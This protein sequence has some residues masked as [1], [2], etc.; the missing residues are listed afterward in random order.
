MLG[1]KPPFF[2]PKIFKRRGLCC[3]KSPVSFE[4]LRILFHNYHILY[5]LY[6]LSI[7]SQ[8]GSPLLLRFLLPDL[9][10]LSILTSKI[11]GQ[12]QIRSPLPQRKM[13]APH[14]CASPSDKIRQFS[15]IFE[16]IR[17]NPPPG[18]SS[19]RPGIHPLAPPTRPAGRAYKK[20]AGAVPAGECLS[21]VAAV[22]I[23]FLISAEPG[24]GFLL[25]LQELQLLCPASLPVLQPWQPSGRWIQP[26]RLFP[27]RGC[28]RNQL[29]RGRPWRW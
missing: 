6:I 10:G 16:I 1:R 29:L 11:S 22:C 7:D 21:A 12:P 14:V 13:L 26:E 2:G 28:L 3:L 17:Q 15:T 20:P 19:A 25:L 18:P 9:G 23:L 27:C 4:I 24:P 8:R 5:Y